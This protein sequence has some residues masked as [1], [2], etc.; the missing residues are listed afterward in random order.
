VTDNNTLKPQPLARIGQ[1]D[2]D[3]HIMPDDLGP[4]RPLGWR[5]WVGGAVTLTLWLV[6]LALVCIGAWT[7]GQWAM[8]GGA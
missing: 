5:L 1:G 3:R 4:V 2:T 8:G 6:V 7:V